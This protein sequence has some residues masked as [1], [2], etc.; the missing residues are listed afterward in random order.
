MPVFL[1]RVF[2]LLAVTIAIGCE[3]A[4]VREEALIDTVIEERE[5]LLI[6]GRERL[7]QVVNEYPVKQERNEVVIE[8]ATVR[9]EG[10]QLALVD[11]GLK[12]H[13][14]TFEKPIEGNLTVFFSE[15]EVTNLMYAK[16]LADRQLFRDD[17]ELAEASAIPI[18]STAGAFVEIHRGTDLWRDGSMPVNRED[19]PD[20]L[21]T[22]RQGMAF[23]EWLNDRYSLKGRFRLPF[24]EEW[25]YAAYGPDRQYPWGDEEHRWSSDTTHSVYSRPELITPDGLLGMWGNVSELVLSRSDGYGGTVGD[26]EIPYITKWLGTSY[27]DRKAEPRQKYWGYTHSP[28]CRSSERGFRVCYVASKGERPD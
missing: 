7:E 22:V 6:E 27:R 20:S 8:A 14:V 9:Q 23:C 24:T 13:Q 12:F 16:Y 5:L 11:L 10:K 21:V 28:R 2:V 15:T 18:T 4:G 1:A 19:H 17:S 26:D 25:V 3:E